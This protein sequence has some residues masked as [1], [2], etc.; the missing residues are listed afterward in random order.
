M[1]S[2]SLLQGIFLTQGLNLDLHNGRQIPYHLSHQG[3]Q[4]KTKPGRLWRASRLPSRFNKWAEEKMNFTFKDRR[5]RGSGRPA[6][7][8]AFEKAESVCVARVYPA[9]R[10]CPQAAHPGK[11]RSNPPPGGG[12]APCMRL[13]GS[14]ARVTPSGRELLIQSLCETG[15]L[16]AFC[17]VSLFKT[18]V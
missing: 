12:E 10:A 9:V 6:G 4:E 5:E 11:G 1:G 14:Q 13:W 16:P 2:C 3:S 17:L 15:R 18:G 7:R 8:A